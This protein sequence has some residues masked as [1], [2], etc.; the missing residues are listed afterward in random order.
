MKERKR[1]K[2]QQEPILKHRPRTRLLVQP[3]PFLFS[4]VDGRLMKN[5]PAAPA[6]PKRAKNSRK[7]GRRVAIV[8]NN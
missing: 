7:T 6:K 2:V 3:W 5:V 1:I 4:V 8:I